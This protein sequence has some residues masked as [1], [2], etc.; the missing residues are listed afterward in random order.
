RKWLFQATTTFEAGLLRAE[1][2]AEELDVSLRSIGDAVLATDEHGAITLL[3]PEAERLTGWSDAEARGRPLAEV[4]PIFN[5]QTG[6][7]A[8]NPVARVLREGMVVG[9]ANHTVLRP[10]GGAPEIP[11]EDSA[12]PI[13]HADGAVR[14]VILVFHAVTEKRARE[15]AVREA[16]WRSRAALEVA[17]AGAYAWET[18]RDSVVGDATMARLYGI[19]LEQC[20]AGTPV[21]AYLS[22][23]HEDDLAGVQAKIEATRQTG[24]PFRSEYRVRGADG[25]ERWVDARGRLEPATSA[26]PERLVG[27]VLDSTKRK[28]AEAAV[29]AAREKAEAALRAAAE[30][31][32][33]F[34]ILADT[35]AL[36]VWTARPDGGL[37]WANHH[38]EEYFGTTDLERE[39]LGMAWA[40]KVHPD[41]LPEASARWTQALATGQRY[42]TEFRLRRADGV[43]GWFLVRA[44]AMR[45]GT[46]KILR[47][48]GTNTDIDDLKVA[49]QKA[50][51]AAQAKDHFLAAL[52]HELRTP[53]TPV[54]MTAAALREDERL[55]A[56][57]REQLG[58]ME[59]NIALEA[60]LIDDL[61]DLTAIAK[62][63]LPLRLQPCDA[64]SLI[65]LAVE[66]ARDDAQTK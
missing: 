27:L 22:A 20:L 14:G 50:E 18:E 60:R 29:I 35:V 7:P 38:V 26:T 61:L 23:I 2:R 47:W 40:E 21:A 46:G 32:E 41:D 34:H 25:S 1:L 55:P 15:R 52:S 19:P 5:E 17:N 6:A 57:V 62:G 43:Y 13:F 44:E 24:V 11:I 64:H 59:R 49:Q 9:L 51:N 66:I 48:F 16:E 56:D 36:Q 54:L 10:R 63:K 65:G 53:L 58:M 45:D 42:E 37:D 31:A 8:D 12:A 28:A 39:V 33:R 4:F 3:N 30:G